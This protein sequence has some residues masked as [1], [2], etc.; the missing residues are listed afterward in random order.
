V[1]RPGRVLATWGPPLALLAGLVLLWQ[2]WVVIQG[3]EPYVLPSPGR[4]VGAAWTSAHLLPEHVGV[5][6]LEAV[7]GLVL[8][9]VI[10]AAVAVAVAT[11][12]LVRRVLEP[13][14]VVSQTVP[15]LV[16]A[17]LLVLWFGFGYSPKIVVVALIAFFPVAV[18]TAQGLQ[19]A[20]RDL[21]ELVR[22]MGATPRQTL[23]M[24]QLPAAVPAFFAGLR[25][26][27]AYAVAGAVVGEW[28]GAERGLGIFITRSQ[29]SYRVDRIFVAVV[30][31][32]ALSMALFAIVTQ[33]GRWAAPWDHR[34][35]PSP[36]S[37]ENR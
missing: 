3:T 17:P 36:S 11:V 10:G 5:T 26:A 7:I 12:P 25:I 27:A 4:I 24:V 28:V 21:V 35:H 22:G 8:G 20:D 1:N 32:S 18:S 29:A 6:L 2:A 33:A 15:M 14:L 31:I 30:L 9:A 13:L 19:G 37:E 34:S 23:R 16:L